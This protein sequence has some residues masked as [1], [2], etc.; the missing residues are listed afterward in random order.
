MCA[1]LMVKVETNAADII[2]VSLKMAYYVRLKHV[3]E[4]TNN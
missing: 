4:L 3:R 1:L 2:E